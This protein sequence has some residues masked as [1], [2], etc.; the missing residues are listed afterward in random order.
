VGSAEGMRACVHEC[1]RAWPIDGSLAMFSLP[2]YVE[3]IRKNNMEPLLQVW[4]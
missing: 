3:F 2:S 4:F 1:M